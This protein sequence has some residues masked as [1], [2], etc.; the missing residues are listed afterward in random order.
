MFLRTKS[1]CTVTCRKSCWTLLKTHWTILD[2]NQADCNSHNTHPDPHTVLE[3]MHH[4]VLLPHNNTH[5]LFLT[6]LLMLWGNSCLVMCSRLLTGVSSYETIKHEL[7]K[8]LPVFGIFP[9]LSSK[10]VVTV[11]GVKGRAVH[12]KYPS[13]FIDRCCLALWVSMFN[14]LFLF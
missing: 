12:Q 4:L 9:L 1:R 5:R 2:T 3:L 10:W 13:H 8:G 6:S 7:R 11:D 14:F